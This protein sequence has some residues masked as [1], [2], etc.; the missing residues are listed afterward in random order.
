MTRAESQPLLERLIGL[1]EV[2]R[3]PLSPA[4]QQLY[5]EALQDL[6]LPPVLAALGT[7][8]RTARWFPK[9]A[10]IRQLVEGDAEAR[11]EQAWLA[12]RTAARRVGAYR[13]VLVADP[14]LAET[15]TAV[16]GGWVAACAADFSPEM[17]ASKRKEFGRVYQVL[18]GRALTGPRELPGLAP[19]RPVPLEGQ[20][21]LRAL[22]AGV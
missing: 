7:L 17:W 13:P 3:A 22:G 10:E 1:S 5:F 15:L 8:A 19:G 2:F 18:A 12:W 4:A 9:P 6:D 21:S 14:V 20:P 16:F 11:V